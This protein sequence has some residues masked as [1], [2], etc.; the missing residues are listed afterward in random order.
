VGWLGIMAGAGVFVAALVVPLGDPAFLI[1]L[2]VG[3]RARWLILDSDST[4]APP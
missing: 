1:A 4:Q 2:A 3:P